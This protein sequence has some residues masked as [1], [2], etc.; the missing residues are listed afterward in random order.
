MNDLSAQIEIDTSKI[1]IDSEMSANGLSVKYH[2]TMGSITWDPS[3]YTL[4]KSPAQVRGLTVSGR[5]L[6]RQVMSLPVV[7]AVVL[8]CLY[9]NQNFIPKEWECYESIFFWGT[10][11][12]HARGFDAVRCLFSLGNRW[13]V[14][15]KDLDKEFDADEVALIAL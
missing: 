4:W 7:N 14:S 8:D 11:Y 6:K 12:G 3:K 13:H 15:Y 10:E 2:Q 1:P 5:V 9:A